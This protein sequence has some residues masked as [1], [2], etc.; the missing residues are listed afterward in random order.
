MACAAIVLRIL[1]GGDEHLWLLFG[2]VAGLGMLN[3]HSMLFFGSGL[4]AGLLLT[5][6]RWVFRSIGFGSARELSC[7]FF[8][9]TCSGKCVITIR[10][11]SCCKR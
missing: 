2:V 8:Y 6:A 7:F 1:N 10:R 9:R 11:F 4:T 3:K 5:R